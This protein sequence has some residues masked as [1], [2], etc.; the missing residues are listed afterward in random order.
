MAVR[1]LRRSRW[2]PLLDRPEVRPALALAGGGELSASMLRAAWPARRTPYRLTGD[3]W[4]PSGPWIPE[5]DQT[6][7]RGANVVVQLNLPR[8]ESLWHRRCAGTPRR[9]PFES[10]WHPVHQGPLLTLAWVRVDVEEATHEALVEE[11]QSDFVR[12]F[13]TLVNNRPEGSSAPIARAAAA[14]VARHGKLWA[15]AVLAAAAQLCTRRLGIR[16]VFLHTPGSHRRLKRMGGCWQ[17]PR[18]LYTDLP[19]RCGFRRT[20]ERPALLQ[21]DPDRG[22]QRRLRLADVGFWLLAL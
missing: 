4:N 21:Q 11:V 12:E 22:L 17:P 19:P 7:R 2:A 10:W 6:S 8:G 1:T 13:R 9:H 15:E 18:S 20:S 5:L 3:V 16:R 14:C